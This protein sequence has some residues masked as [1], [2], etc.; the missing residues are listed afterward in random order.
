MSFYLTTIANIKCVV[1]DPRGIDLPKKQRKFLRDHNLKIEERKCYFDDNFDKNLLEN[2]SL[3]VGMHSDEATVP[4]VT[5]S[6]KHSKNFA[7]VP[8]CVFPCKFPDRVLKNGEKVI[9]YQHLVK[10]IEELV[11]DSSTDFLNIEGR[12]RIIYKIFTNN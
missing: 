7:V 3:I 1:V 11:V 6:I 4:I 5:T 2:C 8:C 10:Y 12:N 9:E